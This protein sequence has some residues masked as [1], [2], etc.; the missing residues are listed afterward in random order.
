MP[1]ITDLPEVFFSD[2]VG[3]EPAPIDYDTGAGLETAKI[4]LQSLYNYFLP[5]GSII[6]FAGSSIP[7]GWKDCDGSAIS[8]TT[9]ANLFAVI[10]T[11]WG[12]G[13]GSTTFN[14]PD[15]RGRTLLGTGTGSGL[16]AR[17]IAGTGGT[18]THTLVTAEIPSH[19]HA[20]GSGTS[21]IGAGAPNNAPVGTGA[22]NWGTNATTGNRGGDGAHNNMQPW[23]CVRYL[24]KY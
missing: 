9:Y 6:A 24:I 11:T 18:E 21:F 10:G 4:Q 20:P 14:I 13:N 15:F 16:T 5:P 12:A 7:A 3:T 8:R 22:N 1:V 19:N 23:A 2:L 17:S